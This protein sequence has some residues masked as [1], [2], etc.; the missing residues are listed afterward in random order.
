MQYFFQIFQYGSWE[1]LKFRCR[2]LFCFTSSLEM[3]VFFRLKSVNM[4]Q[5][6]KVCIDIESVD[7]IQW[8]INIVPIDNTYE[9]MK[10]DSYDKE[11]SVSNKQGIHFNR[12]CMGPWWTWSRPCTS[13]L[14]LAW[15]RRRRRRQEHL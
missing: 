5:Y 15:S 13:T 3:T 12:S 10:I 6:L 9:I 4:Y 14:L 7:M 8:F 2:L 11:I 1:F